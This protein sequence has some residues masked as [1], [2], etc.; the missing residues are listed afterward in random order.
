M[1]VVDP[2]GKA[3]RRGRTAS[4]LAGVLLFSGAVTAIGTC[5]H[6]KNAKLKA[7]RATIRGR[8]QLDR[9]YGL[10]G[11]KLES[12]IR[13]FKDVKAAGGSGGVLWYEPLE[14]NLRFGKIPISYVRFEVARNVISAIEFDIGRERDSASLL[15]AF[16]TRFGPGQVMPFKF[17]FVVWEGSLCRLQYAHSPGKWR[18]RISCNVLQV[19][20]ARRNS[21]PEKTANITSRCGPGQ[22][23][24]RSY[25]RRNGTYV[26]GYCRSK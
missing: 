5:A 17:T 16:R 22:V 24:V 6:W 20:P 18:G 25:V 3:I 13:N 26:R 14:Q 10:F 21:L 2:A 11:I 8:I 23:W 12:S 19:L 7:E 1:K 4:V 9:D 15:A